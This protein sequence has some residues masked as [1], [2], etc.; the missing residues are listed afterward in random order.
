[1]KTKSLEPSTLGIALRGLGL[2]SLIAVAHLGVSNYMGYKLAN[3]LLER[4]GDKR[5]EV[6]QKFEGNYQRFSP[7]EK[8]LRLGSHLAFKKH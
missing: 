7:S 8:L 6:A 2:A 3:S 5:Y 4:M 1:M